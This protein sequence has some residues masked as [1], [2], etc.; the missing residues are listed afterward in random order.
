MNRKDATN[1]FK[2][3]D[4]CTFN[5]FFFR[6][7]RSVH[8]LAESTIA[9]SCYKIGHGQN[10]DMSKIWTCPPTSPLLRSHRVLISSSLAHL[11]TARHL[12]RYKQKALAGT[13]EEEEEEEEEERQKQH[14][15]N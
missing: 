2:G 5:L 10:L 14:N 1:K 8:L 7:K 9:T 6:P 4:N 15:T 11:N 3:F 12:S 13:P